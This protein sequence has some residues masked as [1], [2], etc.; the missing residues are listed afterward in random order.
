MHLFYFTLFHCDDSAEI[1]LYAKYGH[2]K[3]TRKKHGGFANVVMCVNVLLYNIYFTS[4]TPTSGG[5]ATI[6]VHLNSFKTTKV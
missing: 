3:K 1:G 2:D 6:V 5:A 4:T